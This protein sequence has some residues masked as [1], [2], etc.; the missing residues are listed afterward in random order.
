MKDG[1]L[2]TVEVITEQQDPPKG[3]VNTKSLRTRPSN[4]PPPP[5]YMLGI[6]DVMSV[7]MMLPT[8]IFKDLFIVLFRTVNSTTRSPFIN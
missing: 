8:V 4:P 3:F 1:L 7:D 6:T 5:A 2:G